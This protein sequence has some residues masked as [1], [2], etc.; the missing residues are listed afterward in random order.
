MFGEI[1]P[2]RGKSENSY[3]FS[4]AVLGLGGSRKKGA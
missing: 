1:A 2:E 4:F 3:Y